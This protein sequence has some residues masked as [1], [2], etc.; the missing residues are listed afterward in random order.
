VNLTSLGMLIQVMLGTA[1]AGDQGLLLHIA[2]D[3][4]GFLISP[5]ITRTRGA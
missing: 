4:P 5:L 3:W 1:S 2:D